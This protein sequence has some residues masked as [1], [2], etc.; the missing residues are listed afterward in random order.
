MVMTSPYNYDE[1]DPLKR[2]PLANYA[3]GNP[4]VGMTPPIVAPPQQPSPQILTPQNQQAIT[5]HRTVGNPLPPPPVAMPEVPD[6]AQVEPENHGLNSVGQKLAEYGKHY[7]YGSA[8]VD[9]GGKMVG[10]VPGTDRRAHLEALGIADPTSEVRQTPEGWQIDPAHE[11]G[12]KYGVVHGLLQGALEGAARTGK[13]QGAAGGAAVGAAA[14]G[15]SPRFAQAMDRTRETGREQ[16]EYDRELGNQAKQ[17]ALGLQRSQ[18]EENYA[19]AQRQRIGTPH[20]IQKDDGSWVAAYDDRA[21]PVSEGGSA[22]K[23]KDPDATTPYQ[24]SQLNET[25]R[26][27]D[28]Q[29]VKEQRDKVDVTIGGKKYRVS[30]NTAAS[31]ADR[32]RRDAKKPTP[33]SKAS[34]LAMIE[35]DAEQNALQR[36]KDTDTRIAE[37]QAKKDKLTHRSV[38]NADGSWGWE[39][40]IGAVLTSKSGV[41]DLD[42]QIADLQKESDNQQRI[43]ETAAGNKRKAEAEARAGGMSPQWHGGESRSSKG[44]PASGQKFNLGAWKADHPDATPEQIDAKRKQYSGYT[45]TE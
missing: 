18:T 29:N 1:L 25:K 38:Q 45:I 8:H 33:G 32:Q 4:N 27:H 17:Q 2:R 21:Y 6:T 15:V 43:A 23:G 24:Q 7:A 37:L 5:R 39:E 36:R 30:S 9:E 13:W 11:R 20:Y 35:D 10:T 28:M 12:R 22:V 41:T 34:I 44:R 16:T 19:Q 26:W 42:K 31:I 40:D 14:G 3:P